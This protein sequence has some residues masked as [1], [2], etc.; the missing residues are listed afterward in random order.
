MTTDELNARFAKLIEDHGG[1]IPM[2][3]SSWDNERA[4]VDEDE[5]YREVFKAIRDGAENARELAAECVKFAELP[6][7]RWYA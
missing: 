3:N 2:S 5:I 6:H 7:S 1:S 4:H